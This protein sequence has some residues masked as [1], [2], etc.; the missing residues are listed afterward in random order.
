MSDEETQELDWTEQDLAEM[1]DETLIEYMNERPKD[2]LGHVA[3]QIRSEVLDEVFGPG[4]S[5]QDERLRDTGAHGGRLQ[6]MTKRSRDRFA[7]HQ[8]N[9]DSGLGDLI[10]TTFDE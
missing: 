10:P 1:D 8:S 3:R 2:F 7:E 9:L 6:A 4:P 5:Y